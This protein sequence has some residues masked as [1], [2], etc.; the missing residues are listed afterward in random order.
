M[1]DKIKFGK[2][3]E[4]YCHRCNIYHQ[5]ESE[6]CWNCDG[7]IELSNHKRHYF[8]DNPERILYSHGRYRTKIKQ[9]DLPE[10]YVKGYFGGGRWGYL[11]AK[12]IKHLIYSPNYNINNHC[13]KYDS[14]YISWSDEIIPYKD[15]Y[16]YKSYKNYD[17]VIGR[18]FILDFVDAVDKYSNYDV[19][20][21]K[22]AL[23]RKRK[24]FE[25]AN[26]DYMNRV[27]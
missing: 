1:E 21:I 11:S 2:L 17:V 14:L 16:G 3:N 4:K 27:V 5:V 24:W 26:P 20:N 9:E 18:S 10:W 15:E 22:K 6:K 12:D 13:Y 19:R 7:K 23:T 8:A 25:K